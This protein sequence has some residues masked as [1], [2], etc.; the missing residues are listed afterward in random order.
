MTIEARRIQR[1]VGAGILALALILIAA[2]PIARADTIYPDNVITGTDFT[3]G[4]TGSGGSG[5]TALSNSCTL[6]L[7]LIP[8][9]DP[10]T[11]NSNTTHAAG[12]GTPPG[13][14][15]QAYSPPA[16]GLGALL[17]NATTVAESSTFTIGA[18]G[19]TTFQFDRRADVLALLN[20]G[21]EATYTWT[22]VNVT[23]GGA[24]TELYSETLTDQDNVFA[25]AL[26]DA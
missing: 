14:M 24:R 10:A 5:W 20:F 22:L 2:V 21:S 6:L 26:R 4:L 15:Q 16:N 17:F 3:A 1:G 12:I 25:G 8:T 7:G 9:N 19:P 18:S 13:S 23:T 11:C